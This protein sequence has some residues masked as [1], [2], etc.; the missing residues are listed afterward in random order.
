MIFLWILFAGALMAQTTV[1]QASVDRTAAPPASANP[2]IVPPPGAGTVESPPAKP[3]PAKAAET[4]QS[5]MEKQRAAIAI[6]RLAVKKQRD[7]A[8]PWMLGTPRS[9]AA[10]GSEGAVEDCDPI[11]DPTSGGEEA[12]RF[13]GSLDVGDTAKRCGSG[14]R[15]RCRG[16]C[17]HRRSDVWR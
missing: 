16:L 13:G 11:G 2:G 5:A 12:A 15:G 9:D 1:P 8:V 4:L 7:S 3:P 14:Q 10:A 6:Q 17:P